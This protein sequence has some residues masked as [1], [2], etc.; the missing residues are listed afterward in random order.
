MSFVKI[1]ILA[2]GTGSNFEAITKE[3]IHVSLLICNVPNAP[4]IDKAKKLNVPVVIINHLEF[5]TRLAFDT[6][7]S[8]TLWAHDI[9]LVVMAGWMRIASKPLL[10]TFSNRIINIHPSLLPRHKGFNAVKQAIDEGYC[11]TGCTVHFVNEEVDSGEIIDQST[12]DIFYGDTVEDVHLRIKE[13]EHILYPQVIKHLIR[14]QFWL[15][16]PE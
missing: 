15:H 10:D 14:N 1:A 9:D 12:V 2:S 8:Q 7:V 16:G 5:K 13:Q 11:I 3:G 6:A 4:V